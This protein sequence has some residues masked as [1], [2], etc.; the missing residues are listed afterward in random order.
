MTDIEF[1]QVTL[2][3][4]T[5]YPN[6]HVFPDKYAM[7]LWFQMLGDLEYNQ[8][9]NAVAEH[10]VNSTFPPSIAE[11]RQRCV[12]PRIDIPDWAEAWE[13]VQK[14]I[15]YYGAYRDD[16]A[17]ASLDEVTRAA[18]R[19]MGYKSLC[20]AELRNSE[21]DRAQF[22]EIYNLVAQPLI[23]DS[24]LPPFILAQ[25]ENIRREYLD[26]KKNEPPEQISTEELIAAE[27]AHRAKPEH[28]SGLMENAKRLLGLKI[29]K[30]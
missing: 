13:K 25:K 27:Q 29:E 21:T 7:K 4:K 9:A 24:R 14:A 3:I 28:V 1:E 5:A 18:V 8:V 30:S 20:F 15:R 19:R 23:E 26:T 11:I 6:A 17:I 12:K 2:T 22:R 10:I 16:E